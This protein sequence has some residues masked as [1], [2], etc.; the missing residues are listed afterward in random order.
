VK[1]THGELRT[2]REIKA[3]T[4]CIKV[5]IIGR[6][7][8]RVCE[9]HSLEGGVIQAGMA[10]EA[11]G[12]DGVT[13]LGSEAYFCATVRWGGGE[14]RKAE[15]QTGKAKLK[16]EPTSGEMARNLSRMT[17]HRKK[18]IG[19]LLKGKVSKGKGTTA[20]RHRLPIEAQ[21][22][23]QHFVQGPKKDVRRKVEVGRKTLRSEEEK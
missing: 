1:G 8:K 15:G 20:T 9:A 2:W 12:S 21:K 17:I 3:K 5:G 6:G 18:T 14:F 22:V 13:F 16:Q 19:E 23:T 10:L 4:S 7:G 11:T